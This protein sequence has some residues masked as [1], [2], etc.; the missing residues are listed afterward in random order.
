MHRCIGVSKH[1]LKS[2]FLTT[3]LQQKQFPLKHFYL[4]AFV[5]ICKI[6]SSAAQK[7]KDYQ[8]L[9][10]SSNGAVLNSLLNSA[11]IFR[12][13]IELLQLKV[14]HHCDKIKNLHLRYG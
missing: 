12:Y 4:E 11:E 7:C 3:K 5:Q 10:L 6:E 1:V 13:L 14:K 8:K 2:G 9:Q